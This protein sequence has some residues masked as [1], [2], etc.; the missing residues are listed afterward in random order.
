[1]IY[2][3][4]ILIGIFVMGYL[5]KDIYFENWEFVIFVFL[6][7]LVVMFFFV[8][9]M[10]DI[11]WQGVFWASWVVSHIVLCL[12]LVERFWGYD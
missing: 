8:M 10:F 2:L 3:G 6:W 11:D 12:I 1:M 4:Y 7:P 9:L 5:R